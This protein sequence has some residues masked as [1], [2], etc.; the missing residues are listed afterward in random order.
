MTLYYYDPAYM[1]HD[2]GAHPENAGRLQAVTRHLSFLGLDALCKRQA[3]PPVSLERLSYV[4]TPAYIASLEAFAQQGGGRLDEDT[5]VCPRSYEVALIAA[6][7][8]VD[9]V[10][11]VV[12]GVDRTA[13]CLSRPP[14]HHALPDRGMGFCLFNN[15]AVAA[16]VARR[17]LGL[18]RV[19][20]VDWDV[21][22]GNGTQDIFYSDPTVG[23]LSMHRW[24]FWP[25]TGA[26]DET[27]SG[28]GIGTTRNLPIAFGTSREEQLSRFT[29]ELNEF[30]D[31]IR[32]ELIL[33]SAGFDSHR[34]DPVGSLGLETEDFVELTRVVLAVAE[35]HAQGRLVSVLEGGYNPAALTDCV[36]AHLETLLHG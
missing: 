26:A 9:A 28:A 24:P 34:T 16:A 10:E 30:A 14:G 8:V 32:P 27:G 18:E 1:E 11:Q 21:H 33:V 35:R 29:S 2:T 4:H 19:L 20:I 25:G 12:R 31:T 17:E 7:A 6:G 15:V 5:V 3:C 22:H 36:E 13:F 23:F